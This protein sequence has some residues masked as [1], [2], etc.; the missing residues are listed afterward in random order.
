MKVI[1]VLFA[2]FAIAYSN[3]YDVEVKLGSKAF[4]KIEKTALKLVIIGPHG[5]QDV[6]RI[7]EKA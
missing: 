5:Q 7:K 6:F 2:L 3:S 1:L 4:D